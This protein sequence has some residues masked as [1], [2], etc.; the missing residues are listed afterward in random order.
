MATQPL[1]FPREVEQ[2]TGTSGAEPTRHRYAAA[3]LPG[4]HVPRETTSGR[5]LPEREPRA[6]PAETALF[7][8]HLFAR[9][10]KLRFPGKRSGA[11][12]GAD[13]E[14]A[15][16]PGADALPASLGAGAAP[17][18]REQQPRVASRSTESRHRRGLRAQQ[19]PPL[20]SLGRRRGA[21]E[22]TTSG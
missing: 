9:P 6:R 10:Q 13:R 16:T 4:G 7:Q 20:S 3:S 2:D 8:M 21:D 14:A 11:R 22:V 19:M 1:T 18:S 17:P 12:G 15:A 5:F